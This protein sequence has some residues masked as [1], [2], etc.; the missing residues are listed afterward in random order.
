MFQFVD[1]I[2]SVSRQDRRRVLIDEIVATID[3]VEHM[4]FPVVFLGVAKCR[5]NA[6]LGGSGMRTGRIEL[7]NYRDIRASRHLNGSHQSGAPGAHDHRIVSVI[8]H[9]VS[10][11][12]RT[13]LAK[14]SD[15]HVLNRDRALVS[16]S[17]KGIERIGIGEVHN[18][19]DI[20]AQPSNHFGCSAVVS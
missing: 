4:P 14:L 8:A 16:I 15:A 2:D 5:G 17:R 13:W 11:G 19:S 1:R 18:P 9:A 6:T 3:G 7:A 10:P 20:L 12:Q